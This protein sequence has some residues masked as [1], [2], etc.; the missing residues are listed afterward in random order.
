M[1]SPQGSR[2]RLFRSES[3][4]KIGGVAGG[5]AEILEIDPTLVRLLWILVVLVTSGVGLLA[6]LAMWAIVPPRSEVMAGAGAESD[7][8]DP[9]SPTAESGTEPAP[10]PDPAAAVRRRSNAP[11]VAGLVLIVIGV[12]FLIDNWVSLQFWSYLGDLISLAL[13][14]WPAI[15]IAAGAMLV[16]TRLR[17]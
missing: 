5:L 2:F 3:D 13:R 4:C 11:V 14:F 12:L 17:R 8:S 16:Y 9:A 7:R 6:Y 1:S 10:G 15:L